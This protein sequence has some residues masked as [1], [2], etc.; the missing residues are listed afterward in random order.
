MSRN[1]IS[2]M[3]FAASLTAG[4]VIH[5]S[6]GS[7]QA[8]NESAP[9]V[10][11]AEAR[12]R[13]AAVDPDA[14]AARSRVETAAWQRRAAVTNL[15]TPN[16]TA[17]LSYTHF[18]EPFFNFGTGSISPNAASATLDGRYTLLGAGKFGQLRSSRA[19]VESAEA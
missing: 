12:R 4:G 17:G 15:L 1:N 8:T 14:V 19:S 13:A 9:V 7:A 11:L 5:P 18:S 3:I 10:T 6:A 2:T 16:V